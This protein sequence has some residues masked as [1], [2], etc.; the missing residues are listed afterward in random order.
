MLDTLEPDQNADWKKHVGPLVHAYNCTGHEQTGYRRFLLMFG[1]KPR[2]PVDLAFGIERGEKQHVNHSKYIDELQT[3][4]KS[5]Y[6]LAT[7]SVDK[8]RDKQ[9]DHCDRRVRGATVQCG[10]RVL[11]K[12]LVDEESISCQ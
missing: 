6:E 1:R 11:V 4:L 7:R 10:D 8:A 9:K 12:K 5:S 3:R 2:L